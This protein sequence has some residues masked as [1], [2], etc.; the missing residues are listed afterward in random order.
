[1]PRTHRRPEGRVGTRPEGQ[2]GMSNR[3]TLL[4]PRGY[5]HLSIH[6]SLLWTIR[7]WMASTPASKGWNSTQVKFKIYLTLTCRVRPNGTNSS[8]NS[9]RTLTRCWDNSKK[10]RQPTGGARGTT[11][12]PRPRAT[13]GRTSVEAPCIFYLCILF[14]AFIY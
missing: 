10:R 2:D 9:L 12:D 7:S 3:L 4:T 1:M 6:D 8:S 14:C 13:L 5:H 11:L